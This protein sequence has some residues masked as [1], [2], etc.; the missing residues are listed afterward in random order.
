MRPDP[1]SWRVRL[2]TCA[3]MYTCERTWYS[4]LP[5]SL[6]LAYTSIMTSVCCDWCVAST[7]LAWPCWWTGSD[8]RHWNSR[9]VL[10]G[11][12]FLI[13]RR[14]H[15]RL[16]AVAFVHQPT[17]SHH[18]WFMLYIHINII[19]VQKNELKKYFTFRDG[20][21]TIIHHPS[22]PTPPHYRHTYHTSL[23]ATSAN[24]QDTSTSLPSRT[25]GRKDRKD[26]RLPHH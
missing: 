11:R 6:V 7:L 15:V 2:P 24:I 13:A 19:Y 21:D 23:T 4:R 1:R 10:S 22:T 25:H 20:T 8:F 17:H 5:L 9:P 18:K 3:A 16:S 12:Y 26:A 14:T